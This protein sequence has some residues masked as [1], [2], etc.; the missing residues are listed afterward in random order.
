MVSRKID[1]SE[2]SAN[3][4]MALSLMLSGN[5]VF[6]CG[7]AG[8]GKSSLIQI[9][10]EKYQGNCVVVAPTGVAAINVEGQTI[11]SFFMLPPSLMTEDTVQDIVDKEDWRSSL[12]ELEDNSD[13]EY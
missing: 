13:D 11:H 2:L 4:K 1:E 12:G 5:N 8:T 9:F 3:Q 10:K 7:S 6:L